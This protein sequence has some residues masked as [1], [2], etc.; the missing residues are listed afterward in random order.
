LFIH[1]GGTILQRASLP[2]PNVAA[3]IGA[4]AAIIVSVLVEG[5]LWQVWR[6]AAMAL[7][8]MGIALSY[9]LHRQWKA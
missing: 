6:L 5:S 3:V 1:F 7:A 8:G 9:S 4:L 2:T